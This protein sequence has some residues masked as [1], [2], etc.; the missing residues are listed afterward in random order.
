MQILKLHG[1]ASILEYQ[2]NIMLYERC[3]K[4]L[5]QKVALGYLLHF[6]QNGSSNN[7]LTKTSFAQKC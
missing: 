2:K 3:R 7:I 5:F 6:V 1:P 4:I